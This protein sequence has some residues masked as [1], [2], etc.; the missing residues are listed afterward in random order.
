M[1]RQCKPHVWPELAEETSKLDDALAILAAH[2]RDA[3]LEA[4]AMSAKELLRSS[5]LEQSL[6]KVI[7]RLGQVTG[8][9]RVHI[10]E[11]DADT[12]PEHSPVIHHYVWSAPG[13]SSS[14][15][16]QEIKDP[17]AD[18]GL[19]HYLHFPHD[20]ARVIHNADA[21]L[22]DRNVQSSKMVHGSRFSF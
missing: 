9:D 7:E 8:V 5:D 11:I 22:L 2:R 18:V 6:P 20:L 3:I 12:S 17:M 10:L 15:N 13:V 4:V 14:I 1:T 21:G 19:K 16:Y